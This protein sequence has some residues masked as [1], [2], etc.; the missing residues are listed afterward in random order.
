MGLNECI[1]GDG[2][3]AV[4]MFVTCID[5][6]LF[7]SFFF[8][9]PLKLHRKEY[10]ASVRRHSQISSEMLNQALA[11]LLKDIHRFVSKSLR[12]YFGCVLWVVVLQKEEC[13]HSGPKHCG[14]G[15]YQ[16]CLC[17][18]LDS[19]RPDHSSNFCCPTRRCCH[20]HH[21]FLY[22]WCWP[23]DI[24][25]DSSRHMFDIQAKKTN[26]CLIIAEIFVCHGLGI[27]HLPFWQTPDRLFVSFAK[28]CT[29]SG[30]LPYRPDML[31][32]AEM[33][34]LLKYSSLSAEKCWNC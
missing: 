19:F 3:E 33:V 4:V 1:D 22:G 8:A 9:K 26:L 5:T 14:E 6:W 28:E 32:V 13:F 29:L 20:H 7:L 2:L 21:A 24:C 34:D 30:T 25:L 12:C 16:G 31:S 18:F 23:G 27:L 11:G 15:Y 17:T 10:R